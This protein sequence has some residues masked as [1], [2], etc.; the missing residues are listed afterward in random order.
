VAG[1]CLCRRGGILACTARGLPS[2]TRFASCSATRNEVI[3]MYDVP[4]MPT[5]PFDHF[6][7][8]IQS[9]TSA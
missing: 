4:F 9:S 7:A 5:L 1:V 3:P 6:W 8:W 2:R